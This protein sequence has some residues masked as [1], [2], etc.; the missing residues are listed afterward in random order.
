MLSIYRKTH[1]ILD[2]VRRY[3]ALTPEHR[4]KERLRQLVFGRALKRLDQVQVPLYPYGSLSMRVSPQQ[5]IGRDIFLNGLYERLYALKFSELIN[6]GD[7]VLDIGANSG[8][9]TLLSALMTGD[10]GHVYA[11]EP[12]PHKYEELTTHVELNPLK[13]VSCLPYA[14]SNQDGFAH[15]NVMRDDNDGMHHLV[16]DTAECSG[17]VVKVETKTINTF[18]NSLS[19]HQEIDVIKIDV[20]GWEES[21]FCGASKLFGQKKPPTIFLESIEE[22]ANRFGLSALRLRDM[23]INHGYSLIDRDPATRCWRQIVDPHD[24]KHINLFAVHPSRS[25]VLNRLIY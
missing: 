8:Q 15:M 3:C 24:Q 14:L 17:S 5:E 11:F 4:G 19:S 16:S 22:H 21:V 7:I 12:T 2:A 20:E 18:L 1:P 25:D 13:N 10:L 9:Y 6:S 23:L